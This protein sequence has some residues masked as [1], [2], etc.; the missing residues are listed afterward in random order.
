MEG[1][2]RSVIAVCER[3]MAKNTGF[4]FM[5]QGPRVAK[6]D[7]RLLLRMYK[8]ELGRIAFGLNQPH[9]KALL[10]EAAEALDIGF[11]IALGKVLSRAPIPPAGHKRLS[12]LESFLLSHWAESKD[13]LPELFY[14][15]RDGLAD[16]CSHFLKKD[17]SDDAVVKARQRLG[18][19]PFK[20]QKK[21]VIRVGE[22]LKFQ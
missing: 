8:W 12:E 6:L 4:Y 17:Y 14:L 10:L 1:I 15:T 21:H 7:R 19:R 5:G 3:W 13:G 2:R 18:L 9:V 16:V 20:R 22:T 11:F